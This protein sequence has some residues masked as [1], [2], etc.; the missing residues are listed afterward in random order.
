MTVAEARARRVVFV[1]RFYW[2]DHSATAQMLTD[3][4]VE[5]AA[6]G[7]PVTVIAS[8]LRYDGGDLLP[9]RET[10]AGVTIERVT[11]SR[12]G[13]ARLVGRAIDYASFYV[14]A[15][16]A[17]ARL[18]RRGD[19]VV[20]KTDPPLLQIPLGLIARLR[21]ARLINWMQ[22]VY[23]ELAV[24]LGIGALRGLPAHLLIALRAHTLRRSA[25]TVVIGERMGAMLAAA[26]A[27][28]ETL[29]EI[30]NW[31]DDAVL[32]Q[33]PGV[34][35]LRSAWGLAPDRLVVAYSGN[36]GRA[37]DLETILGAA[38][39]LATENAAVDFLFIGAGALGD[40]LDAA[41]LP[42]L[43]RRPYQAREDLPQSLGVGDIH[44]M[45]LRPELEGMIVPSKFYGAAASARPILFVGAPDGELARLIRE[46]DCGWAF[47]P[48]DVLEIAAL[49]RKLAD[50]RGALESA[51]A[52]A[53]RMIEARF[54]RA[55]SAE[56]WD[57]LLRDVSPGG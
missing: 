42:N 9:R 5:L 30:H 25:R 51:G 16:L 54:T 56:R 32:A 52:N 45:S 24:A 43:H 4:A 17:A 48:D 26:G 6:R 39:M 20:A 12:F 15:S 28:A 10:H 37:H 49:L 47:A 31:G 19:I 55:R 27:P 57:T 33:T 50:D 1:N 14:T 41:G 7:W 21:R 38:R 46:H 40:R 8:R 34:S 2:P 29:A 22:D 18:L 11:T 36:L 53:R 3:L 13:R 44:W 35:P 23:P